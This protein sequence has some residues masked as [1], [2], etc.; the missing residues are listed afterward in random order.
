MLPGE[1]E[2][3]VRE[4]FYQARPL[5]DFGIYL[6]G[7]SQTSFNNKQCTLQSHNLHFSTANL[8][9]YPHASE[10]LRVLSISAH[11]ITENEQANI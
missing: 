11:A 7:I 3:A 5:S 8:L 2:F 1:V 6:I 9:F 4:L 10:F